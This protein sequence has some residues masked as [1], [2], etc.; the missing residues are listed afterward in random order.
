MLGVIITGVLL[1]WGTAVDLLIILMHFFSKIRDKKGI[2]NIYIGQFL[3]SELLIMISLVF[4][5]ILHFVPNKQLLGILGLVPIFLGLK[6][7]I[8]GDTGG[9]ELAKEKLNSAQK[10]N[11]TKNICLITLVSCGADNIGLFVPYFISLTPLNLVITLIVFTIMIYC[12]VYLA[13]RLATIPTI[14]NLLERYSRWFISSVYI[15]LGISIL[16]ENDSL[17]FLIKLL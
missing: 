6:V 16:M 1:Y 14:G 10:L 2:K 9:E 5:Y 17:T 15:I 4:A 11:L 13:H 3:G 7:L 12:L 8:V